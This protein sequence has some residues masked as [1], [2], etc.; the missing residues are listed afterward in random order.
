MAKIFFLLLFNDLPSLYNQTINVFKY[1]IM[2]APYALHP[3]FHLWHPKFL[4]MFTFKTWKWFLSKKKKKREN[5]G[6]YIWYWYRI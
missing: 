5:G 1:S 2:Y 4:M 6:V 3:Q